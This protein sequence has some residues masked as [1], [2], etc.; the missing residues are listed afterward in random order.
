MSICQWFRLRNSADDPGDL[1]FLSLSLIID[2]YCYPAVELKLLNFVI[3]SGWFFANGFVSGV[4]TLRKLLPVC[5]ALPLLAP[6]LIAPA[7][8]DQDGIS[9]MLGRSVRRASAGT[10]CWMPH[11]QRRLH[12]APVLA[13]VEAARVLFPFRTR[14]PPQY[15]I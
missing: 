7:S 6:F 4:W 9:V 14:G 3:S 1:L 15:R 8:I 12:P 2:F 10:G 11:P 13:Q 5:R